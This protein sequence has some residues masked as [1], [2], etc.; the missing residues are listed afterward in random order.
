[1]P[2]PPLRIPPCDTQIPFF[3]GPCFFI[4]PFCL[5]TQPLLPPNFRQ[6]PPSTVLENLY[7]KA[8]ESFPM[9]AIIPNNPTFQPKIT[10][11]T[12]TDNLSRQIIPLKPIPKTKINPYNN[13]DGKRNSC[14]Y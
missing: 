8:P 1:M 4:T 13:S 12:H 7:M 9:N 11:P 10:L 3:A 6:H 14:I 5:S 2:E